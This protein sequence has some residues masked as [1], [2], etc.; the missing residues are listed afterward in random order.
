MF[1]L[2]I[3]LFYQPVWRTTKLFLIVILLSSTCNLFFYFNAASFLENIEKL[4]IYQYF[5]YE[6]HKN[7][8]YA[9]EKYK[10]K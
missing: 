5:R 9:N 8:K 6:I 10:K 7:K 3:K 4:N 1:I 2:A